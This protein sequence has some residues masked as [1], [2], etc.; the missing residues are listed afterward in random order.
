MLELDKQRKNTH[1]EDLEAG[2][3]EY[4]NEVLSLH[5]LGVQCLVHTGY[6]PLEHSVV[7]RLGQGSNGEVHL[8][9]VLA[10]GHI[11]VTDLYLGLQQSLQQ[12]VGVDSQKEGNLLGLCY[13]KGTK[14]QS[15]QKNHI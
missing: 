8:V 6:Q 12:V 1:V 11:L 5:G 7:Q 2:N 10:L 3:I 15:Q 13:S 9:F 4:T 14:A